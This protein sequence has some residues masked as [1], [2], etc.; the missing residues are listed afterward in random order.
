L[1]IRWW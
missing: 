1:Y